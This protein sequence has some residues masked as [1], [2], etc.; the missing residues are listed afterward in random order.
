LPF[1]TKAKS[2]RCRRSNN[3]HTVVKIFIALLGLIFACGCS[4]NKTLAHRLKDADRV[5]VT[6]AFD[7]SGITITDEELAKII[8]AIAA[9]EKEPPSIAASV[10]FNLL[11]FKGTNFLV[12]VPTCLA[13]FWAGDHAYKD[14]TGT[15]EAS[16]AKCRAARPPSTFSR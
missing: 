11:F 13:V 15:L 5:I 14:R 12:S 3:D 16:K 10:D 9:G 7:G 6:N 1:T 8:N 4:P 2:K